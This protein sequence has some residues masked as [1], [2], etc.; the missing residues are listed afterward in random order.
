MVRNLRRYSYLWPITRQPLGRQPESFT[1]DTLLRPDA[2]WNIAPLTP[3]KSVTGEVESST[4]S[5]GQMSGKA[6]NQVAIP[7]SSA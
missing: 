2:M 5:I 6:M 3:D 4:R 7:N 1:I